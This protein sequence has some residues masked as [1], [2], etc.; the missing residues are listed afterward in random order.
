MV[1]IVEQATRQAAIDGLVVITMKQVTDDRGT[2]REFFRRSAF[3]AAGLPA[4][5]PFL[6]VNVTESRR[7]GDTRAARR[8][9][10]EDSSPSS[11]AR[12]SP[13]MSTC[14]WARRPSASSRR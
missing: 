4:M 12:R 5:E 13:P 6:Q 11:P 2:V 1:D 7:G 8:D 9:D 3:D 14:A 10:D